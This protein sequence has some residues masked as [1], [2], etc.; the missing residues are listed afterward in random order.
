MITNNNITYFKKGLNAITKIETWTKYEFGNVWEFG[1]KNSTISDGINRNK[2]IDVRIPMKYVDNID[3]FSLGDIIV[4]GSHADINEQQ[5]LEG[6]EFYVVS[7]IS[8]NNFGNNP[9]IHLSGN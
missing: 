8:I 7:G 5:D 4:V 1:R 9:H 3:L 2:I 6:T